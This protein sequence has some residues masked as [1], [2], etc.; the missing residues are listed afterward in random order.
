MRNNPR[1]RLDL[2]DKIRHPY[3]RDVS[4][5]DIDLPSFSL[6]ACEFVVAQ[7]LYVNAA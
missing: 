3:C 2:S 4:L 5:A 1:R 6:V 7:L